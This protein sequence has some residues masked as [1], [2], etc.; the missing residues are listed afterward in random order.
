AGVITWAFSPIKFQAD[1]G[2]LLAFMFLLNMVGAVVLIPALSHFLLPSGLKARGKQP[3][4]S[5]LEG[6]A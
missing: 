3:K 6:T 1:M 4:V 5:T 2:I